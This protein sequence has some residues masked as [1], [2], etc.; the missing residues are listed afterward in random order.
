M[1]T[2][3]KD[4]EEQEADSKHQDIKRKLGLPE[5]NLLYFIEKRAPKWQD[6]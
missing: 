5:E 3:E 1:P 2:P 4:E 6:E